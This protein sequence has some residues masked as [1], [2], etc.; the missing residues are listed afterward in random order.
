MKL[1]I[2]DVPMA[3]LTGLPLTPEHWKQIARNATWQTTRMNLNTFE[4]H[5]AFADEEVVRAV[6]ERL[7]DPKE[8]RR[9]KAFPY[10]LLIAF[11]HAVSAPAAV[12]EALQDAMEH[13]TVNVPELGGKVWVLCDVSPSMR[14]PVTGVRA[15]ATSKVQCIDVA[16]LVSACILRKN[17]SA[18]V[19]PFS[20]LVH[21]ERLNPRDSVM[22]NASRLSALPGNG[23]DCSAPL[24][25]MNERSDRGDLVI[26]V[27]DNE[28]WVDAGRG[29]RGTATLK[30]WNRFKARSPRAR[31]VCL[32][33]TPNAT[34]QA[35]DRP[36][37]LNIG[38]FSDA[39]FDLVAEFA[40]GSSDARHWVK[41]IEGVDV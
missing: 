6:A 9:A 8:V 39:V 16:A 14:S 21:D 34:T 3:L 5:G 40:R 36:D 33:L 17:P 35:L 11:K 20:T 25:L 12:R 10:Q 15:G 27:S 31:L 19:L 22:T 7:K 4:R 29:G 1:S 18:G 41:V 23:T 24:R 32:D 28:S 38:G 2:P 30:E 26:L 13:A 37:I